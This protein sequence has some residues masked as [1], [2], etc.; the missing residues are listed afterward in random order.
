MAEEPGQIEAVSED[1]HEEDIA[2]ANQAYQA[3]RQAYRNEE[4]KRRQAAVG[5]SSTKP[6]VAQRQHSDLGGSSAPTKST[7]AAPET[8]KPSPASDPLDAKPPLQ[9]GGLL[10]DRARMEQERLARQAAR[11]GTV[12]TSSSPSTSLATSAIHSKRAPEASKPR[13]ATLGD[14]RAEVVKPSGSAYSGQTTSSS[15][16]PHPTS[17][18]AHPLQSSGPFPTDAAGEIYLEGEMRHTAMS[19]GTSSSYRTFT[20]EQVVGNVS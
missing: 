16:R 14:Y 1:D 19:I 8:V 17:K 3:S 20:P 18:S 13:V 4:S 7:A 15:N 10:G 6:E 11:L 12:N 9:V 2:R 5:S